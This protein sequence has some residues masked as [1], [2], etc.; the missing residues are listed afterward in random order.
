MA[1]RPLFAAAAAVAARKVVGVPLLI[2]KRS[3]V[4]IVG[5]CTDVHPYLVPQAANTGEVRAAN[6]LGVCYEKGMG[7][8]ED[9]VKAV[10]WYSSVR[11][12]PKCMTQ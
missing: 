12:D 3:G 11:R 7:T 6:N 1:P 4:T 10:H 8:D 2:T 5:A 9:H